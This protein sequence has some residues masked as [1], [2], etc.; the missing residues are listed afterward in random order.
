MS[1][2]PKKR[3]RP[4]QLPPK[5]K[6]RVVRGCDRQEAEGARILRG[7]KTR[8]S[9]CGNDKGDVKNFFAREEAKTTSK[10]SLAIKMEVLCKI[11]REARAEGKVPILQLGF[12][13]MPGEFSSDWFA[14]PADVFD[15]MCGVLTAVN[16]SQF[17]E[18]QEW[19]KRLC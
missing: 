2:R 9:G 6:D 13:K 11:C 7:E 18:A 5:R 10:G 19:L 3:N 4:V 16:G 17:E 12:D 8:G 14:V 1:L 15:V